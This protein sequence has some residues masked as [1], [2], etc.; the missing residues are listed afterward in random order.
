MDAPHVLVLDVLRSKKHDKY[1]G[2][3]SYYDIAVLTTTQ[4][5]TTEVTQ[6]CF[7]NGISKPQ[8]FIPL[9]GFVL[10]CFC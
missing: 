10:Y 5:E 7:K 9:F 8:L 3:S 2:K 6:K 4:I 1:D